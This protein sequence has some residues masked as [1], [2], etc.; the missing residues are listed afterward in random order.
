MPV[1]LFET[2]YLD[3][4]ANYALE[5]NLMTSFVN[6]LAA[7]IEGAIFCAHAGLSPELYD[8][9]MVNDELIISK[10]ILIQKKNILK[11]VISI[12]LFV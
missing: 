6:F 11:P 2:S 3:F 8:V 4:A 5:K 7:I 9:D 10:F 1:F 12:K